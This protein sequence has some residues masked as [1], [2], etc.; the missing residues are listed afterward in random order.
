MYHAPLGRFLQRDPNEYGDGMNLYEFVGGAPTM[1]Q[2]PF[3]LVFTGPMVVGLPSGLGM[4]EV[5]TEKPVCSMQ[6]Y[7]AG[8]KALDYKSEKPEI[9]WLPVFFDGNKVLAKRTGTVEVI[10][11]RDGYAQESFVFNRMVKVRKYEAIS[12]IRLSSQTPGTGGGIGPMG[13]GSKALIY[14]W[15]LSYTVGVSGLYRVFSGRAS[16][17]AFL[18]NDAH[19]DVDP[20]A[21]V[22]VDEIKMFQFATKRHQEKKRSSGKIKQ[23]SSLG[24]EASPARAI[25]DWFF[26]KKKEEKKG[27]PKI[28][29]E[30][31][32]GANR[33]YWFQTA[34]VKIDFSGTTADGDAV[35]PVRPG[36]LGLF[37][38]PLW[39]EVRV[40]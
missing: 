25:I 29:H 27:G 19:V 2:D 34:K 6:V 12:G 32:F 40:P 20:M 11:D 33:N 22:D 16:I 5:Q 38:G 3:G 37:A 18:E 10:T 13:F 36:V 15:E 30:L 7:V 28:A 23:G 39:Y 9:L 35:V 31:V 21:A 14:Y 4:F 8:V 26:E 1:R 24:G 17:Q